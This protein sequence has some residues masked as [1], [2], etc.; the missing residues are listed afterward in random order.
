M[1]LVNHKPSVSPEHLKVKVDILSEKVF[2]E[3]HLKVTEILFS[4]LQKDAHCNYFYP[5]GGQFIDFRIVPIGDLSEYESIGSN[6][7]GHI[8]VARATSG[9][10]K[11]QDIRNNILNNHWKLK[12]LPIQG[13]ELP[14]GTIRIINGRTRLKF[15][16]EQKV[17]NCIV[18]IFKFD[19]TKDYLA[20]TIKQNMENDPA[21]N[22]LMKDV[23]TT[24]QTVI[25]DG[26]IVKE[27]N[28]NF[29]QDIHD[30]VLRACADGIFTPATLDKI[31]TTIF[32]H[33]DKRNY[34]AQYDIAEVTK[35]MNSHGY[36]K[37]ES[38]A[39]NATLFENTKDKKDDYLYYVVSHSAS[40]KNIVNAAIILNKE[41]NADKKLRIVVHTGTLPASIATK[42]DLAIKYNELIE[43]HNDKFNNYYNMIKETLFA[44]EPIMASVV[45]KSNRVIL[46]GSLPAIT[47]KHNMDKILKV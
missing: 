47:G 1:Q 35:W 28:A 24:G 19:N 44:S 27:G 17:L 10:P 30:W 32:N 4:S 23:I 14:D 15:L 7:G 22:A 42:T 2:T 46:Y 33:H 43:K 38:S 29:K 18:A 40:M 36:K 25:T 31:T 3:I 12:C 11:E 37:V 9:N 20:E 26:F 16:R 39:K 8:Q 34:I 5:E 41:E 45:K 21:G 13:E 6:Q